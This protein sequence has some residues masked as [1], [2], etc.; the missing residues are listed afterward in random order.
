MREKNAPFEYEEVVKLI[1]SL[2]KQVKGDFKP[3]LHVSS[4]ELMDYF[5]RL[6]RGSFGEDEFSRRMAFDKIPVIRLAAL[7]ALWRLRGGNQQFISPDFIIR[8]DNQLASVEVKNYKWE[9]LIEDLNISRD[10]YQRCQKFKYLWK[11]DKSC[12]ALKRFQKWYLLDLEQVKTEVLRKKIKI[13]FKDANKNNLIVEDL[14]VF[15]CGGEYTTNYTKTHYKTPLKE[16]KKTG[17]WYKD[18]YSINRLE[19]KDEPKKNP[20]HLSYGT[21][22]T[23]SKMHQF[24]YPENLIILL[25]HEIIEEGFREIFSKGFEF[26]SL[27]YTED[28]LPTKFSI[29]DRL[30]ENEEI[31]DITGIFN[32]LENDLLIIGDNLSTHDYA[33]RIA[34]IIW[35]K[36]EKRLEKLGIKTKM[37]DIKLII[38]ELERLKRVFRKDF[39]E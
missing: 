2:V 15:I 26:D 32:R 31:K 18:L 29:A 5:Y 12:I 25:I 8:I 1:L 33:H 13:S 3:T 11:L 27:N 35:R 16:I 9:S 34:S 17:I 23:N 6:T 38:K 19:I 28:L 4:A 21:G 22:K 20:I 39:E 14:V 36:Y 7:P 30:R 24:N 10:T 37:K